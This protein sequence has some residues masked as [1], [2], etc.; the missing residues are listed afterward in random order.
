M[1]LGT[2]NKCAW[3]QLKY[4]PGYY[5]KGKER[6]SKR[7]SKI[8]PILNIILILV[9][10]CGFGEGAAFQFQSQSA[11]IQNG[12]KGKGQ[13]ALTCCWLARPFWQHLGTSKSYTQRCWGNHVVRRAVLESDCMLGLCPKDQI[14]ICQSVNMIFTYSFYSSSSSLTFFLSLLGRLQVQYSLGCGIHQ[15]I[16]IWFWCLH[17]WPQ[18][19]PEITFF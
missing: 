5:N 7:I 15:G 9:A 1:P 13:L 6:I 2:A 4:R 18:S 3:S 14:N 12:S 11:E 10:V 16:H 17:T 8:S 19:S